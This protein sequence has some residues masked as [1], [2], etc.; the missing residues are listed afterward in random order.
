MSS[1]Q[2]IG[3]DENKEELF[4]FLGKQLAS[5]DTGDKIIISTLSEAVV[6]SVM[7]HNTDGLQPCSHEEADTRIFLRVKDA[8]NSGF[9]TVMIRT[10]DTDVVVLAVANFQDFENLEQLWI[11]FGTG[12]DFRYICKCSR[13]S[14]CKR[15]AIFSCLY[16]LGQHVLL[17]QL[18]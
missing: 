7:D 11:A 8:M 13:P 12:K 2:D 5:K 16:G 14:G 6:T 17:C 3:N 1:F 18:W 9:K 15:F 10:V 4:Q